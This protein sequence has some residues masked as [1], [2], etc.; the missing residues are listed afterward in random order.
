MT[1][2]LWGFAGGLLIGLACALYML[3]N[4]RIAGISGILG[5]LIDR[6]GW[7][8]WPD[9]ALFIAGLVGVPAL[10]VWATP[11]AASHITGNL[12]VIVTGG[13]LVGTGTR[14]ANGCTSGHGVCGMAR[15]SPRSIVSTALYLL[16]GAV[17]MALFR[18]VI[19]AI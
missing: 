13:L 5:G 14:L 1:S 7:T 6:T 3:I 17:T 10:I 8:D 4:G 12:L 15:M 16:A 9:R 18:H 19:G 11:G 2:Y